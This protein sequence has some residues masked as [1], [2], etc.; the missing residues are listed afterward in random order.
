MPFKGDR[1]PFNRRSRS[2][3]GAGH[4]EPFNRRDRQH[5]GFVVSQHDPDKRDL[6]GV[7]LD[8]Q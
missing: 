3:L 7:T 6:I 5:S 1:E 4:G 2:W 8:P